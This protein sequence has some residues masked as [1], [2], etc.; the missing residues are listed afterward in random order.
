MP[1]IW[2]SIYNRSD[3]QKWRKNKQSA[4]ASQVCCEPWLFN[5]IASLYISLTSNRSTS[6]GLP[7]TRIRVPVQYHLLELSATGP[8]IRPDFYYS[9][10]VFPRWI[11]PTSDFATT[12]PWLIGERRPTPDILAFT[13]AIF[14]RWIDCTIHAHSPDIWPKYKPHDYWSF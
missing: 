8:K 4:S 6:L 10:L 1:T 9:L 7:R 5:A 12:E 14:R 13:G 11:P 2:R 3:R